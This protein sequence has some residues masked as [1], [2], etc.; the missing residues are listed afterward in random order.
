MTAKR[1]VI[2]IFGATLWT[3][4]LE[5]TTHLSALTW[6]W[7]AIYVATL[8]YGFCLFGEI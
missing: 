8:I 7:W 5:I 1:L 3:A 6:Q 2:L 4:T